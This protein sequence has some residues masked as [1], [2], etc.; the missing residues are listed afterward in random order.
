MRTAATTVICTLSLHDALPIYHEVDATAEQ[1]RYLDLLILQAE[2]AG[3]GLD[4][5]AQ[6]RLK[7]INQQLAAQESAYSRLQV[8]EAAESAVYVS[9]ADKLAGLEP[10]Q[11][12]AAASAAQQAG[13]ESGY[14]LHLTMPV[15]Q[16]ALGSLTDRQ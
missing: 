9:S 2:V 8:L 11:L 1:R 12:A 7:L 5:E 15:Q 14:M 10:P 16:A 6:Q 4:P 3:A 13:Y